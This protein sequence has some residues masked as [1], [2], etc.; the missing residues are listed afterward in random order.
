MLSSRKRRTL[1]VCALGFAFEF[2]SYWPSL[3][4]TG[5]QSA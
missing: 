3:I 5:V 1:S 2:E 4:T